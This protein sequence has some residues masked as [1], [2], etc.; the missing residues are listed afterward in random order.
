MLLDRYADKMGISFSR[1]QSKALLTSQKSESGKLIL[2]KPQTMMNLSGEAV[3]PL[4]RYYR[5]AVEHV[6]VIY[7]DLDLP[8]ARLRLRPGGGSGGH[9]GISSIICRL[10]RDDFPRLRVGIGRPPG[11]LDPADYVLQDF[12]SQELNALELTFAK[13]IDCIDMWLHEG[14]QQAMTDCNQSSDL[15]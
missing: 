11:R 3:A 7:D 12:S 5:L 8:H 15:R 6:L 14:L 10:G 2:A 13:A 9:L 1:V 4:V